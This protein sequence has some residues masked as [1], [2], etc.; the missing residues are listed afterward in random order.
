[1]PL[2]PLGDETPP[3]CRHITKEAALHVLL[4]MQKVVGS[5]PISRFG[6]PAICGSLSLDQ[7]GSASASGRTD[8]GL[9]GEASVGRL[10]ESAGLQAILV[11]SNR[12]ASAG[13][14]E[15]QTFCLLRPLAGS[16]CNYAFS[17]ADACRAGYH[18]SGSAA[19]VRFQ[20][21]NREVN[22]G[23]PRRAIADCHVRCD[24]RARRRGTLVLDLV[25]TRC[26][27]THGRAR[28]APDSRGIE[29]LA[30]FG[31]P[32]LAQLPPL[33][34]GRVQAALIQRLLAR[35]RRRHSTCV[36]GTCS[37]AP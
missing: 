34:R 20:S 30:E 29:L 16:S 19:P 3:L 12:R 26:A 27:I 14:T 25:P 36:T 18:R 37:R 10:Q 9:A 5:N 28:A 7:S 35:P 6:R 4:A 11:G 2:G 8:S 32:Q 23:P 17:R 21:G 1:M 31:L 13:C 22:L 33:C 24:V 15:R